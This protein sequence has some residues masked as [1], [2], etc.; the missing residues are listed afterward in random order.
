MRKKAILFMFIAFPWMAFGGF[1]ASSAEQNQEAEL[2]GTIAD[3]QSGV[4][5]PGVTLT[6]TNLETGFSTVLLSRSEGAYRFPT[7]SPGQYRLTV[8]SVG[9]RKQIYSSLTLIPSQHAEFNVPLQLL[10]EAGTS[11]LLIEA[12]PSVGTTTA[13]TARSAPPESTS[14]W[15]SGS[16]MEDR[17]VSRVPP[18]YPLEARR[19]GVAGVVV[20]EAQIRTDGTVGDVKVIVG[21]QLLAQAAVDAVKRRLYKPTLLQGAAV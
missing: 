12:P 9:Y 17:I 2:K 10:N 13:E 7:L 11:P 8:E 20:L 14:M 18:V 16:A 4:K 3:G 19:A 5:I 6:M 15:I 1:A 21:H